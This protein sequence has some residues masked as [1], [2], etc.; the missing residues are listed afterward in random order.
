L[1]LCAHQVTHAIVAE[2]GAA[3]LSAKATAIL[4]KVLVPNPAPAVHVAVFD[5]V[6]SAAGSRTNMPCVFGSLLYLMV[7]P[8]PAVTDIVSVVKSVAQPTKRALIEPQ[9]TA[10][11]TT[12]PT[13]VPGDACTFGVAAAT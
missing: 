6:T 9:A 13:P 2:L 4:P 7:K 5:P 3:E 11:L 1:K 8:G 12:A 10:L